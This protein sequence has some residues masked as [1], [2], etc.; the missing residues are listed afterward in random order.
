M[1]MT[2]DM[3]T[4]LEALR[5]AAE[6]DEGDGWAL[7]YLDNAKPREWN[8]RKWAALLGKLKTTGF[9]R[10]FDDGEFDG[11]FGLVKTA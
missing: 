4:A 9:Y 8:G 2:T 1:T 10:D 7:V 3:S 5:G 6:R 11:V